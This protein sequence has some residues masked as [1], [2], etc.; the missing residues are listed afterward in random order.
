MKKAIETLMEEHRLIEL[1]LGSL[2][3]F[4]CGIEAGGAAPREAIR[5]YA[6][7]FSNF[8]DKCHHGK[9]DDQLFALMAKNGF[10]TEYGPIAVMLS[11][12][13]EGRDHV[14]AL[15][16]L[17]GGSG[18]LSG[19]ERE[20][21]VRQAGSY[22]AML[23]SHI[24]K[25][26][27]ILYPMALQAIKEEDMDELAEKFDAFERGVMGEGAHERFHALAEELIAAYPPGE[28]RMSAAPA[29]AGCSGHA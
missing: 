3:T 26:D 4:A 10:P 6:E 22:V 19:Q 2:E 21:A 12:H 9:E 27:N 24:I 20:E 5:G 1:V 14:K 25:E 11:D 8:A 23:R 15:A 17:G 16:A 7:F 13:R 28:D 18:P 29:C